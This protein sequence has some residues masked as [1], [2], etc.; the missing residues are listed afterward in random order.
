MYNADYIACHNKSFVFNYDLLKGI[1]DGGTFVLNCPWDLRE[2]DEHLPAS[3]KRAIA[4]KNI[5]FYTIDAISIAGGGAR[6]PHQHDHAGRFLPA[7]QGNSVEE[8]IQH[9]KD[10]VETMYGKGRRVVEM[11]LAAIDRAPAL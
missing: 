5:Q 8:A 4:E 2:L 9:L 6:E 10:S 11:N 3:T 1:K 7:S